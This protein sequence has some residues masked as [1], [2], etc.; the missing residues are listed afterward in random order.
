MGLT[1]FLANKCF[2]Y[3]LSCGSEEEAGISGFRLPESGRT[4][5]ASQSLIRPPWSINHNIFHSCDGCGLC[6]S[7]CG[8]NILTLDN[9]GYPRVDFS[10]GSCSFCGACAESCPQNVFAYDPSLKPWEIQARINSVCLAKKNVICRSCEEQCDKQAIHIPGI[11]DKDKEPRVKSYSCNGCG[12]CYK[13][14]P[15]GAIEIFQGKCQEQP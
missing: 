14:C 5:P 7:S 3:L 13:A 2:E 6:I 4:S 1:S 10:R 12:A 11:V 8:N 15:V 9:K